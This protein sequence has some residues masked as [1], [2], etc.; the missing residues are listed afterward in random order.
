MQK[1]SKQRKQF[2]IISTISGKILGPVRL[3]LQR[4]L[5]LSSAFLN[6]PPFI[7]CSFVLST[8]FSY[9]RHV[10]CLCLGASLSRTNAKGIGSQFMKTRLPDQEEVCEV[11]IEMVYCVA[12]C[13]PSIYSNIEMRKGGWGICYF[14]RQ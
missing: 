6:Q 5:S 8:P 12:E 4:I 7:S 10:Y 3:R 14:I 2:L 11:I 9:L 13:S 1:I